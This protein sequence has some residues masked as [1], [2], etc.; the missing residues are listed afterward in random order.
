M[1][2]DNA[3]RLNVSF[4]HT[5]N[6]EGDV[7]SNW[8]NVAYNQVPHSR[9]QIHGDEMAK[10]YGFKGGL[11][12][13]VTVSA[14]LLHPIV[15]KYGLAFLE[16]GNARCRVNSP[17]YDGETFMVRSSEVDGLFSS[18]L[19]RDDGTPLA[20]AEVRLPDVLPEP[21]VMR[22]DAAISGD[23]PPATR[24]NME[25]L[26]ESGGRSITYHWDETHEMSTY[27]RDRQAMAELFHE[28]GYAN[29]SYILGLSNWS[30]ASNI[31]MNPWVH[32]ETH[33]QNYSAIPKGTVVVAELSIADVFE[34][35]GHE[36]V[37]ADINLFDESDKSCLASIRLRAIYHLRGS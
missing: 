22:G 5:E 37:D 7:M 1:A 26:K 13:G 34:K 12:P 36:F 8:Q 27:L 10:Q 24:E 30:L 6:K 14:Y 19:E 11:V 25:R 29:P 23:A 20:T 17:L 16:R 3:A 21:P 18:V 2:I 15:E 28:K 9:N 33:L 4:W 35:K 31:Y 32:L